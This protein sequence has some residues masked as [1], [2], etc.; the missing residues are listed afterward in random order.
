LQDLRTSQIIQTSILLHQYPLI[1]KRLFDICGSAGQIFTMITAPDRGGVKIPANLEKK[2]KGISEREHQQHLLHTLAWLESPRHRLVHFGSPNYP[3]LLTQIPD[4]P[5]LLY[6]VGD[7]ALLAHPQLAIVGSRNPTQYGRRV[8]R[9]FAQEIAKSG[10]IVTSGM[11]RGIDSTAHRG[12]LDAGC[13]TIAVLGT[14]CDQ[15]YPR[16]NKGLMDEIA[17]L[18]LLV[19]EFPPG[20]GPAAVNFPQRNRIVTGLSCGTVVVEARV[21]SGSLISARLAMEQGRSVFAVPGSVLSKQSEG[22]H[23]LLREGARLTAGVS[24]IIE[25]LSIS[26]PELRFHNEDSVESAISALSE[27][28]QL[29]LRSLDLEPISIDKISE[30]TGILVTEILQTLVGLELLGLINTRA[31]GYQ[32]GVDWKRNGRDG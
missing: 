21:R 27:R 15:A 29:I 31:G 22:C 16:E 11:A 32:L 17:N 19:S 7:L 25:E 5:L 20:T 23:H 1:A 13:P 14:G 9:L 8:T 26:H 6:V 10:I 30:L 3:E 4:P 18:G 2:L 12:A 28:E 24:D